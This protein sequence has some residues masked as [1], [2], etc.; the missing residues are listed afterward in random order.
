MENCL[1]SPGSAADLVKS[2]MNEIDRRLFVAFPRCSRPLRPANNNNDD[3]GSADAR[4]GA[5]FLLQMHDE[6]VYEVSADDVVQVAQI[7]KMVMENASPVLRVRTPVKV[8]VGPT[9]GQL[10]D[11]KEL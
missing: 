10:Q 11:M 8:K 2:A 3:D 6:L 7:V 5:Y 9:W 1:F 4:E